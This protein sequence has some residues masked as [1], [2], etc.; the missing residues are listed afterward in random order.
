MSIP[1][2]SLQEQHIPLRTE[3]LEAI[4]NV[5]DRNN[6]IL[7]ESVKLFEK[8]F[9]EF[10]ETTYCLGVANGL[11][12]IYLSL[13]ALGVKE[14]D[15]VIV[16][17]N[18]YIATWLAVTMTGATIVP[19]EPSLTTYNIQASHISQAITKRTKVIIPVHLYGQPCSMGEIVSLAEK[20][21]IYILE[22][23]AQAHGATY[24]GAKTGSFGE[25]NA[26]SF[27]P[28]KNLGALGDGGAITTNNKDLY[29]KVSSLRNYGSQIKYY[30][31]VLGVNSRLDE[32]QA[33]VLSIKLKHLMNWTEDRR[34]IANSYIQLLNDVKE[35]ILPTTAENCT[36]AY[37]LF[38]IR[39]DQREALKTFLGERDIGT[40]IHYPIPPHLQVA[41]RD[42]NFKKGDFPIA[43]EIAQTCLSLPLWPGL[44][45]V[46]IERICSSIRKFYGR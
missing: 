8:Q 41:Y 5:Y 22:D 24:K 32:I 39:T 27:Y 18:T 42:L 21:S 12:A 16:P 6:F 20:H 17:S 37:H 28:G 43:E 14:G 11:D 29:E 33:V 7:G 30:N 23:N 31:S 46:N 19:V 13:K 40:M 9:G 45:G 26:T 2:L 4:S 15:E 38:V 34:R 10:C 3:I 44:A 1:F 35:I 25:I 36:H